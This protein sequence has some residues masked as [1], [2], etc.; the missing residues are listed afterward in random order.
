MSSYSEFKNDAKSLAWSLIIGAGILLALQLYVVLGALVLLAVILPIVRLLGGKNPSRDLSIKLGT[1]Y[2]LGGSLII[3][4]FIGLFWFLGEVWNTGTDRTVEMSPEYH[5]RVEQ[6]IK[7][8]HK[9]Y[10]K[11]RYLNQN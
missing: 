10:P 7:E 3:L 8:N 4:L 5:K 1:L 2:G 6:I 9:N 11:P